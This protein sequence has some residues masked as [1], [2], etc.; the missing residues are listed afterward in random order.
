MKKFVPR[1]IK[2]L[3]SKQLNQLG[4][5]YI[6][7]LGE[8]RTIEEFQR[9]ATTLF[10][11]RRNQTVE[12]V[13]ALKEK[14]TQPIIG[15]VRVQRLLELLAQV[16]D[17][18][19]LFLYCTSQLTHTLQVLESM[20]EAG[21]TDHDLYVMTLIHDLGKISLLKGE[22][23]ENV[24]CG[25]KIPI[26]ENVPG[27]GFD[28]CNFTW[29]HADIVHARFRP[30]V[31]E[32]IAW[33]LKWHSIQEECYPFMDARDREMFEKYYKIFVGHD[34]TFIFYHRPK[35]L[36][37]SYFSILDE[38]FPKPI[39]FL[40]LIGVKLATTATLLTDR[41]ALSAAW[42]AAATTDFVVPLVA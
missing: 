5:H 29:D 36:I 1:P 14:Y 38:A 23:P 26:G 8:I 39:L 12:T 40:T 6:R 28:N 27:S 32:K 17:P 37:D 42:V 41:V 35:R 11:S 3:V 7:G 16:I 15:E 24:E 34:R 9:D 31:N 22:K 25:G 19:N 20:E 13:A 10:N 30:Y 18:S 2:K 4:F 21:V 33:L